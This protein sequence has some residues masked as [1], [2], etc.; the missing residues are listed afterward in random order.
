MLTHIAGDALTCAGVPLP[1]LWV[2]GRSR[3]RF[4]PLRTGT[5][6][7]KAVLVPAF[8]ATAI[9]FSY[10]NTEARGAVDPWLDKLASLG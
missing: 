6:L 1:L 3:L 9:V 10:L 4:C 2:F 8:L 5:T 7:E